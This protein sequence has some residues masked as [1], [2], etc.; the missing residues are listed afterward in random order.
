MIGPKEKEP[1]SFRRAD[2]E[3]L[4][5]PDYGSGA[6]VRTA[7]GSTASDV[8]TVFDGYIVLSPEGR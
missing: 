4:V 6:G 1:Y 3:P 7:P 5:F 8:I 2:G